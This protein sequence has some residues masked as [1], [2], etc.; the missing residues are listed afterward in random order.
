[1]TDDELDASLREA[2][3]SEATDTASLEKAI[4][5]QTRRFYKGWYVAAAAVA[6]VVL[7][8][9]FMR[10]VPK[11]FHE[12]ARDHRLEVVEHHPRRWQTKAP[13]ALPVTPANYRLEHSKICRIEGKP[14]LHLVYTDG[15]HEVS[16]YVDAATGT[17]EADVDGQHVM[18]FRTPH[19]TGLVV[20]SVSECRQ[21]ADVIQRLT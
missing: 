17:G 7:L 2:I 10:P 15:S 13:E 5:A 14:V 12:A 19:M 3:H 18:A 9:I 20:G 16:V 11:A 21:F 6:A 4:R 1:M 8:A